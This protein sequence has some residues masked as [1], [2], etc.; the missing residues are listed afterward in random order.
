M[1]PTIVRLVLAVLLLTTPSA[2]LLLHSHNFYALESTEF[3]S[4]SDSM[5]RM[6]TCRRDCL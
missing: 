4:S 1:E 3:V 2:P 5:A 6:D